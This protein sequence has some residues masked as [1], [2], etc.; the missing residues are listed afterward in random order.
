MIEREIE[1]FI[2]NRTESS[3]IRVEH[4]PAPK[5]TIKR[6]IVLPYSSRKA[7]GFAKRLKN[8]VTSNYPQVEFNVAFKTPCQIDRFFPFKDNVKIVQ[9]RS[10]VV[11]RIHCSHPDCD[12]SY[13]G[14]TQRIL[15]YRLV[16]HMKGQGNS[17]CRQHE[18][19]N[20]GHKMDYD[21]VEILDSADSNQ[22]LE[23]KELLHIIKEK[24]L[25]QAIER[26]IEI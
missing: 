9:H 25:Q 10:M 23:I 21:E 22:K 16:E 12:A 20:P 7:E 15:G 17:A 13:I 14:K 3:S 5:E 18:R 1:K 11:Y 8:L 4:P 19:E 2:R 6:Y 24:P 26:T